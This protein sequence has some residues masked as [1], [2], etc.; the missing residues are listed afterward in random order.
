MDNTM[1]ERELMPNFDNWL[2][3]NPRESEQAEYEWSEL[4]REKTALQLVCSRCS[5]V[6][7]Y[8]PS[9]RSEIVCSNTS[10][11]YKRKEGDNE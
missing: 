1:G 5:G 8:F 4:Q 7:Y 2:T 11:N 10:C 3:S 6:A 9:E